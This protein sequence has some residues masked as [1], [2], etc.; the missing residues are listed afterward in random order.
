MG[1]VRV[2]DNFSGN[3]GDDVNNVKELFRAIGREA[4]LVVEFRPESVNYA[5]TENAIFSVSES[6]DRK[7]VAQCLI[8]GDSGIIS[9]VTINFN[10]SHRS[11]LERFTKAVETAVKDYSIDIDIV[12]VGGPT[13]SYSRES[14][15]KPRP[16][17]S[18]D[19]P[20]SSPP[21]TRDPYR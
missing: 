8:S 15:D 9:R 6:R 16:S 21:S 13:G 17:S 18:D 12:V 19:G 11:L 7:V 14:P 20:Y 10:N 1:R 2:T 5:D 4:G 3:S